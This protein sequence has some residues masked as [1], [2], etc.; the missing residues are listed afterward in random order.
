MTLLLTA[1]C[2]LLAACCLLP[3]AHCLLFTAA[4]CCKLL[5]TVVGISFTQTHAHTYT[6]TRTR[7]L[8]HAHPHSVPSLP[9]QLCDTLAAFA[10]IW[11]VVSGIIFFLAVV[12]V[13]YPGQAD[14]LSKLLGRGSSGA[15]S[16]ATGSASGKP[17]RGSVVGGVELSTINPIAREPQNW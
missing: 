17:P 13:A 4:W 5:L 11:L 16:L 1:H 3:A 14:W 12:H 15:Q 6:P 9:L 8:I 2:L 7:L 10:W